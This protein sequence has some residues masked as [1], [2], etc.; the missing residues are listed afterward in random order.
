VEAAADGDHDERTREDEDR[1]EAGKRHDRSDDDLGPEA[2]DGSAGDEQDEDAAGLGSVGER[3]LPLG[4]D[5]VAAADVDG[6]L[7][8]EATTK[9]GCPEVSW[10]LGTMTSRDA[11]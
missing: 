6:D 11:R 2:V 1:R 10:A 7:D 3:G 9:F 5:A 4:G 8:A